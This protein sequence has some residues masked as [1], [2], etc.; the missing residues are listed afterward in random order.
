MSDFLDVLAHDA[1]ET[2]D[3]GYYQKL[4]PAA[5][6]HDSLRK[7]SQLMEIIHNKLDYEEILFLATHS[8]QDSMQRMMIQKMAD[9]LRDFLNL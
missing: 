8:V 1:K 7:A 5:S 4:K 6:V 3:S 2:I 9:E